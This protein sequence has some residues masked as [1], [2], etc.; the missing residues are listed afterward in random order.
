MLNSSRTHWSS[1]ELIGNIPY[2]PRNI[3]YVFSIYPTRVSTFPM[4]FSTF[5]T[6]VELIA[7]S[8]EFSRAQSRIFPTRLSI[9][10]TSS[11]YSRRVSQPS[12]RTLNS[13]R[14]HWSSVELSRE[15]SLCASQYS[16]RHIRYLYDVCGRLSDISCLCARHLNIHSES[17]LRTFSENVL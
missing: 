12:Q 15:Y 5:P 7:N 1:D 3:L 2:A 13:S 11:Q 8:L 10:P 14:T 4:R 17:V 16:L 6:H 9:F